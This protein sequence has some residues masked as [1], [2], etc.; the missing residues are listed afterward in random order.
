MAAPSNEGDTWIYPYSVNVGVGET[1]SS[2]PVLSVSM[3]RWFGWAALI[4][5]VLAGA[6]A[7]V[8]SLI[9]G[10]RGR[11]LLVVAG[12]LAVL[13]VSVF[14][15]GMQ[16]ELS[17]ASPNVGYPLNTFP[18]VQPTLV[19]YSYI[20]YYDYGFWIALVA[21][22]LAF[23]SVITHPKDKADSKRVAEPS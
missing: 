9:V 2:G 20:Y 7:I 11:I 17:Q 14:A 4:L 5:I 8:G 6:L 10:R 16:S 22:I 18:T 21:G 23:V 15:G 19:G 12:I 13:S 1:Y 3:N